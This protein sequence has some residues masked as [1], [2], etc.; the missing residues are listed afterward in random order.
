DNDAA[1]AWTSAQSA[2][3]PVLEHGRRRCGTAA[4]GWWP[5]PLRRPGRPGC[6]GRRRSRRPRRRPT[7]WAWLA[8]QLS[9]GQAVASGIYQQQIQHS[10]RAVLVQGVVAVPALGRLPAGRAPVRPLAGGDRAPR[11]AE[12]LGCRVVPAFGET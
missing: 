12:P 6:P 9:R 7:T 5:G 2:R 8:P 1:R 3:V 10:D 11:R 4:P